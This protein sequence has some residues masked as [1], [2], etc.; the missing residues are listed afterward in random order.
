MKENTFSELRSKNG[1]ITKI[2]F[3]VILIK[4]AFLKHG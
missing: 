4:E 3:E 1:N 2:V